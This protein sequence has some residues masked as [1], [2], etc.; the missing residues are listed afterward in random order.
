MAPILLGD[1]RNTLGKGDSPLVPMGLE[2][3]IGGKI[4]TIYSLVVGMRGC[5]LVPILVVTVKKLGKYGE[6]NGSVP[7]VDGSGVRDGRYT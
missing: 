5:L 7:A 4:S 3:S 1:L 6:G 2:V